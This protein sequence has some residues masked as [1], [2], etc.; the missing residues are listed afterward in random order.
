MIAFN[1][2]KKKVAFISSYLP[3]KCGIATFTSDLIN[4]MKLTADEEL[5]PKLKLQISRY[6]CA[7]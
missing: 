7:K 1:K 4:H 5:T 6:L 3:Q 2:K